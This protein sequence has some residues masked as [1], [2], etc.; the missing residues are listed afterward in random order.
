M[1][2]QEENRIANWMIMVYI[3]ADDELANF[4]VGSLKQL[5]SLA[6]QDADVVVAAQFDAN[7]RR[8]IPRLIFKG[9]GEERQ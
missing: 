5:K 1:A 9:A 2:D 6:S 7:G 3:A 8:N 4:A